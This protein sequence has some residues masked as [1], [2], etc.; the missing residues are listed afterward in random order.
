MHSVQFSS[1]QFSSS[2]VFDSLQPHGLQDVRLRCTSAFL[3]LTQIHVHWVRDPIQPSHTLSAWIIF[4]LKKISCFAVRSQEGDWGKR[5]WLM[6]I[7]RYFSFIHSSMNNWMP[8]GCHG[9]FLVLRVHQC[10]K[11]LCVCVCDT[12]RAHVVFSQSTGVTFVED[13]Q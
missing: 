10:T 7:L 9:L 11:Q 4:V 3:E 13:R 1:V 12:E 8:T 6:G 5:S 2:V